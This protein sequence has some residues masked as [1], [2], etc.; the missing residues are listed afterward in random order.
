MSDDRPK[1]DHECFDPCAIC[2]GRDL[3]EIQRL[4]L[5]SGHQAEKAL[6]TK[7]DPDGTDMWAHIHVDASAPHWTTPMS[8]ETAQQA[9]DQWADQKATPNTP[10]IRHRNGTPFHQGWIAGYTAGTNQTR[11]AVQLL[12]SLSINPIIGKELRQLMKQ[13]LKDMQQSA[14]WTG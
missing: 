10:Y 13:T 8:D 3:T 4:N 9:W 14:T 12:Q 2:I 7:A 1:R 11:P 6:V 5:G